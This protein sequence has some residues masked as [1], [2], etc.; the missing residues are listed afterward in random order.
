MKQPSIKLTK[1]PYQPPK[2]LVYGDLTEMTKSAGQKGR[3]D[4]GGQPLKRRTGR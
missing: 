1:K 2:L 3:L 4:G